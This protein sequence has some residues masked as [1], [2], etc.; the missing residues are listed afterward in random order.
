MAEVV[1]VRWPEEGAD[2]ARLAD[3][4]VAVLYLVEGDDDPPA[5]TTCFEDWVRLPGDDRDLSARVAAL[6]LRAAAHDLPPRV[7]DEGRLH[8]RGKLLSLRPSEAQLACVL[9]EHFGDVVTDREL[10]AAAAEGTASESAPALRVQM[11]QLRSRLRELG[12]TL[13]R[14]RRR[15][16]RLQHR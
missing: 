5:P 10:T 4:G 11:A 3:E 14:I 12:L 7:D 1:L 16:Y 13:H 15:G 9:A 2:G 6:Q 8:Y